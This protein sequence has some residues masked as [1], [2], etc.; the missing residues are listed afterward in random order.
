MVGKGKQKVTRSAKNLTRV[1]GKKGPYTT[2]TT[3]HQQATTN[4]RLEVGTPRRLRRDIWQ[5]TT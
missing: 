3:D 2:N 4:R 1:K 5:P